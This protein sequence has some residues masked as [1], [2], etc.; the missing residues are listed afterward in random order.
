MATQSIDRF[1]SIVIPEEEK[2]CQ[3]NG[4]QWHTV[5][6]GYTQGSGVRYGNLYA[7]VL[8][9]LRYALTAFIALHFRLQNL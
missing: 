4:R 9:I 8:F 3:N 1:L 5:G 7:G 6:G 2:V